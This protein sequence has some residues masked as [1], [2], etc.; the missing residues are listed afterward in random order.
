MPTASIHLPIPADN[1]TRARQCNGCRE[2]ILCI[3]LAHT[4][5][6][7]YLYLAAPGPATA[8]VCS[9]ILH[10]EEDKRSRWSVDMLT[11][12]RDIGDHIMTASITLRS[13]TVRRW[14]I[15]MMTARHRLQWGHHRHHCLRPSDLHMT[16][17]SQ[18]RRRLSNARQREATERW[19]LQG[20]QDFSSDANTTN[21][22]IN[23]AWLIRCGASCRMNTGP[24]KTFKGSLLPG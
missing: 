15:V 9:I 4:S 22:E 20:R 2:N 1:K 16:S 3:V 24:W 12:S 11:P 14:L 19:K 23:H 10:R 18:T 6:N 8:P 17:H 13:R 5:H 21:P 7:I